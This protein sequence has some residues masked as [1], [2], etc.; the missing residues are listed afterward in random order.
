VG[1]N[2]GFPSEPNPLP[3]P[4]S[5]VP[6]RVF[7]RFSRAIRRLGSR[8]RLERSR[9]EGRHSYQRGRC[10]GPSGRI[11][12]WNFAVPPPITVGQICRPRMTSCSCQF[13]LRG[14][15]VGCRRDS[16]MLNENQ[17]SDAATHPPTLWIVNGG[18]HASSPR[19][20]LHFNQF[21]FLAVELQCSF[22]NTIELPYLVPARRRFELSRSF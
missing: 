14:Q 22:C 4:S 12:E 5:A 20:F 21:S 10:S 11:A 2:T 6:I 8:S 13:F 9:M 15:Y 3:N 1:G 16:V 7:S 17:A 18:V 19:R